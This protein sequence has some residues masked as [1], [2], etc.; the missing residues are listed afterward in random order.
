MLFVPAGRFFR[1]ALATKSDYCLCFSVACCHLVKFF[2]QLKRDLDGLQGA[3][4]PHGADVTELGLATAPIFLRPTFTP[5]TFMQ[6]ADSGVC[7]HKQGGS[8]H[9][10]DCICVCVGKVVFMWTVY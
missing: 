4:R 9:S 10:S 5:S 3:F 6:F 7:F 1:R 8:A 2:I